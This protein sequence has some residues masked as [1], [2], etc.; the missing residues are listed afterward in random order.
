VRELCTEEE[1]CVRV[2]C[3]ELAAMYMQ[4]KPLVFFKISKP[5]IWYVH[6]RCMCFGTK[7]NFR[8]HGGVKGPSN[9]FWPK[10]R[11]TN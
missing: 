4:A 9:K 3:M 2:T 8:T 7:Q 6:S 11:E 1:M 5:L 10:Q